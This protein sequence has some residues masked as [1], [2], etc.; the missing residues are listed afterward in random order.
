MESDT[1]FFFKFDLEKVITFITLNKNEKLLTV[2]E[3]Y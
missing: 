1:R 2:S 3:K